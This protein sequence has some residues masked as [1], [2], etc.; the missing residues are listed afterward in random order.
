MLLKMSWPVLKLPC[1]QSVLRLNGLSACWGLGFC[2]LPTTISIFHFPAEPK[3]LH[4]ASCSQHCPLFTSLLIQYMPTGSPSTCFTTQS[5]C[6]QLAMAAN[7][8]DM[9]PVSQK[10]HSSNGASN[11]G[12]HPRSSPATVIGTF[13]QWCT[14]SS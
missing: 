1:E 12:H 11:P 8:G 4:P 14:N 6:A 9:P 5:T 7:A 10:H 13:L 2:H 3:F